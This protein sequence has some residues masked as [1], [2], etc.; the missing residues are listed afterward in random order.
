M[1]KVLS[2]KIMGWIIIGGILFAGGLIV[3]TAT[4]LLNS[5]ERA[6]KNWRTY[7]EINSQQ[8]TSLALI[9]KEMGYGGMIH[10]FKNY[11][12]RK[13]PEYYNRVKSA[14]GGTVAALNNYQAAATTPQEREAIQ[15]ILQ[16]VQFYSAK[17]E[18]VRQLIKDGWTSSEIDA[19]VRVD[20]DPALSGFKALQEAMGMQPV[21]GHVTKGD[22]LSQIYTNLG[23]GGLIHHFKNFVLRLDSDRIQKVQI[24][25]EKVKTALRDYQSLGTNETEKRALDDIDSVTDAYLKALDKAINIKTDQGTTE[26][27]DQQI[28]V[29]DS[30]AMAAM[31]TLAQEVASIK[32]R[33]SQELSDTLKNVQNL[34]WLTLIG[35]TVGV[36]LLATGSYL[37]LFRQILNRVGHITHEMTALAAGEEITKLP[38]P[39]MILEIREMVQA[40]Q[41]FQKT[42]KTREQKLSK[43]LEMAEVANTAKSEFLANMSHELRTPLN[44]IIGFSDILKE[45]HQ[46]KLDANKVREYAGDINSSATHL[47]KVI[48][49]ILDLSKIE[50]ADIELH[51]KEFNIHSVIKS[52]LKLVQASAE[53][54]NI[55]LVYTPSEVDFTLTADP[56]R[57]KQILINLLA[58]AVKFTLNGGEIKIRT[59]FSAQQDLVITISDTG[60]GMTSDQITQAMKTFGQIESGIARS[61]EGTG[62]GLPLVNALVEMHDGQFQLISKPGVGTSA[63]ISL[64]HHRIFTRP[65]DIP[66]DTTR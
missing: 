65:K 22:L 11:I 8:S 32:K 49:D 59:D 36:M 19:W 24:A 29:D 23:Y 50:A 43:A 60:I 56:R 10:Q 55:T 40:I 62:L 38:T 16:T 51:V 31:A 61:Y 7:Q 44:A 66:K 35:A 20:D 4:G 58:N 27:L 57:I 13:E 15:I 3:S 63:I 26:A 21:N 45:G 25:A 5:S 52:S 6:D 2:L 54:N 41:V 53:E 64:P 9:V 18:V 46:I 39:S 17:A 14:A 34:L 47:L 33:Q 37:L 1:V 12:I 48:N 42:T 28:R 30:P